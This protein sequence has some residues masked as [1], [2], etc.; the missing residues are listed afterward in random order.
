MNDKDLLNQTERI[1]DIFAKVMLKTMTAGLGD[2]RQGDVSMA[3]FQALRFIGQHGPCTIGGLAEGL[4][5]SQPAATMMA[6]RMVRKGLLARRTG[7]DRRKS[8]L[9][10]TDRARRLLSNAESERAERFSGILSHLRPEEREQ[11]VQSLEQFVTAA[12]EQE[13]ADEACL[14]CGREHVAECVVNR[15]RSG[16]KLKVQGSKLQRPQP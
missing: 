8:Q 14:H 10:L 13:S 2:S 7:E 11:L 9:D 12:L 5:V 15:A 16:S 4:Y 1:S 6:D 3:Q